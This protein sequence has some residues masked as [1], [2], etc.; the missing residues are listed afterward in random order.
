MTQMAESVINTVNLKLV[1]GWLS[2]VELPDAES[3]GGQINVNT[4]SPLGA[5]QFYTDWILQ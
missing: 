4:A 3:G 5:V 2:D 1:S